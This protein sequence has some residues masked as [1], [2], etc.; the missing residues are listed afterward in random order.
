MCIRDRYDVARLKGPK[1]AS[2]EKAFDAISWADLDKAVSGKLAS[3][4][5]IRIV[6]NTIL[7]PSTKRAIGELQAK[8]PS[9]QVVTY[10]PVSSSAILQ[11]NE[12]TFGLK[13]IPNYKFKEADVIVS[14]NADFLGTWI[15]P[16]EYAKDYA[17]NRKLKSIKNATMN[18]HYQV[19]G[20]MSMTGSNADHRIIIKPSELGAAIATLYNEVAALTGGSRVS[21]P[22]LNDKAKAAL[23][24]AAKDLAA[25]TG[26]SLV[27]SGSNNKG[28]QIL[29]NGINSLLGNYG[30]TIDFGNASK[31]RQGIDADV[32]ALVKD[33]NAGRV[34]AL[35]VLGA[36][37]A[38]DLPNAAQFIEGAA[39]VGLK[40][41]TAGSM[42]ETSA[43]CNYIAPASHYLESWGDVEAKSGYY[44]LIQPTIHPLFDTREVGLSLLNWTGSCLLYTSPS[45]RDATLSRMPSSA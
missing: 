23:K 29:V 35:I 25:H 44:S 2:G 26:H 37:P 45:P 39:K 7:S 43:L 19:E 38:F 9:A 18:R 33:M 24:V 31:Q 17:S 14:L 32:Q 11:A 42:N 6:T 22:A 4:R 40:V 27:V 8:Y 3:S 36:N 13:T 15:S 12:T 10:D 41:S 34:D 1:V 16:T 21:A 28:E 30:K 20:H 5:N